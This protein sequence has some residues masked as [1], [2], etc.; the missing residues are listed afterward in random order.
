MN[1]HNLLSASM[2]GVLT[3]A[4][5]A[6]ESAPARPPCVGLIDCS[7]YG[8]CDL[9]RLLQV[10]S[11]AFSF[12]A[13]LSVSGLTLAA[14]AVAIFWR[15]ADRRGACLPPRPR[16]RRQERGVFPNGRWIVTESK[17]HNVMHR[18]SRRRVCHN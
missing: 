6:Q 3:A 12:V 1:R 11:I 16:G 10:A 18:M 15:R 5:M 4:A 9:L 17:D 14:L 7:W 13:Y 2:A 8:K